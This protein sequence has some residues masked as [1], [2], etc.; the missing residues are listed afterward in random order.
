MFKSDFEIITVMVNYR[1]AGFKFKFNLHPPSHCDNNM[2]IAP[3]VNMSVD[4]IFVCENVSLSE[5]CA[6]LLRRWYLVVIPHEMCAIEN[7]YTNYCTIIKT[8][9]TTYFADHFGIKVGVWGTE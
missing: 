6:I 7:Y 1:R 2:K 9:S 3:T 8:C 4:H 5:V